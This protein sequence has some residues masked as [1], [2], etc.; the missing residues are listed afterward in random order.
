MTAWQA[1]L[2]WAFWMG[3]RRA[4]TPLE[5][6]AA[7]HIYWRMR[8]SP[9]SPPRTLGWPRSDSWTR[10]DG[11]E[12]TTD[13]ARTSSDSLPPATWDQSETPPSTP[14]TQG[15][16]AKLNFPG[17]AAPGLFQGFQLNADAAHLDLPVHP[18]V[19]VDA[20]IRSTRGQVT[21]V[22]DLSC[23]ITK[24]DDAGCAK[25]KL[26]PKKPSAQRTRGTAETGQLKELLLRFLFLFQV[27][28]CQ[29]NAP[30]EEDASLAV[31]LHLVSQRDQA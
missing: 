11:G 2:P 26:Y 19:V 22:V 25:A 27:S 18:A 29:A 7:E 4:M 28:S 1:R 8:S 20:A 3:I 15:A 12:T 31:S 10:F 30:Y 21:G 14:N 24:S 17:E 16:V 13:S 6:P 9:G 5:V 23:K